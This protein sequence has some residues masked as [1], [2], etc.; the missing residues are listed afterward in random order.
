MSVEY[1]DLA[2]FLAITELVLEV[3]ADQIS[4]ISRLE[5][6][7]SALHAPAASFGGIEF[8][9][10]LVAK[11]A[12]LC[13]RLVKNHPLPDGNKRVGFVCL[14]E[15]CLRNGL[16]WSPPPGD[17]DGEASAQVILDLAAGPGDN[18]AITTLAEWIRDRT[19][20]PSN[21]PR[22]LDTGDI[23]PTQN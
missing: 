15:F 12:V 20:H 14:I 21:P 9:P 2:D 18:E 17:E 6:A 16:S 22:S 7:E 1:L 19:S 13:T 4:R 10:D 3:P 11:A 23:A 8:Y 5:L